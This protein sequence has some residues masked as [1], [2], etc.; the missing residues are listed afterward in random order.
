MDLYSCIERGHGQLQLGALN[1]VIATS[2]DVDLSEYVLDLLV[3]G[4]CN[5]KAV[6]QDEAAC[7]LGR[8]FQP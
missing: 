3:L 6:K 2:F 1:T 7:H 4:C 5:T 8:A